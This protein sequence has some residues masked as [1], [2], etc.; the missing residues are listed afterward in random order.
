MGHP[1]AGMLKASVDHHS[2][3]QITADQL[4]NALVVNLASHS[5][6]EHVVVDCIKE[7][8]KVHVHGPSVPVFDIGLHLLHCIMG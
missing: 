3:A 6:H 4:Q 1:F 5:V 8:F 7:L 2:G